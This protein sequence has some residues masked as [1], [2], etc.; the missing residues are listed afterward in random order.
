MTTTDPAAT[1]EG[2]PAGS[3]PAG[4]E[5][6]SAPGTSLRQF[7]VSPVSA[8]PVT[9]PVVQL[10]AVRPRGRGLRGRRVLRWGVV[11]AGLLALLLLVIVTV[12]VP[13]VD[14]YLSATVKAQI[15]AQVAVPGA[16]PPQITIRGGRL[17]PQLLDRKLAE[18]QVT[19]PDLDVSGAHHARFEATLHGVTQTGGDTAHAD[20]L[21]AS[22]TLPF[23][24]LPSTPGQPRSTFSRGQ[25][26]SLVVNIP[27]PG[28]TTVTSRVFLKLTVAGEKVRAEP[29][30]MMLFGRMLPP[31][32][33]VKLTGGPRTQA[34][35]HLP[36]GLAYRSI[37]AEA[38][39]LHVALN[40]V[41]T[42]PFSALPTTVGGRTVSY[43]AERGLLGISTAVQVPPIINLPLTIF[44][45][46]QLSQT[47]LTL[48][49]QFVRLLGRD[50]PPGDPLARIVLS[51]V[52]QQDL[53]RQLPALPA[54]VAYRGVTVDNQGVKVV[55]GGVT[56]RP[57]SAVSG[58]PP[59]GTFG[60]SKGLL[61]ATYHGPPTSAGPLPIVMLARP[62]IVG[63][64]LRVQPQRFLILNTLFPAQ[65]VQ[66]EVTLPAT[67]FPLQA[68]PAHLSY[69]GVDVLP[70]ALRLRFSGQDVALT[71][72]AFAPAKGAPPN[73]GT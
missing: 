39:G 19:L 4:A 21:D 62:E 29:L 10:R 1:A 57:F 9:G 63:T 30:G 32:K 70:D 35:P 71:K 20:R 51:Q 48:V 43:V 33:V 24:G 69:T 14:D 31:E 8:C 60:A 41:V 34:L 53:T 58:G 5:G 15:A 67:R 26:G 40:G 2:S 16:A 42:T 73:P 65:M 55:V 47:A 61:T 27:N 17:L 7:P 72:G 56:V 64:E 50:R 37:T 25:D 49:P 36:A 46:P 6:P 68:L 23:T 18:I 28:R 66:K 54:G 12:P 52:Q 3:A 44:V 13:V 11:A 38:D 59:G 45:R 22:V